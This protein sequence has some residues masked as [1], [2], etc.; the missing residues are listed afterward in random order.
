MTSI[1]PYP[2][3]ALAAVER[4]DASLERAARSALT[5]WLDA[6]ALR[7]AAR[8]LLGADIAL[9][10]RP[11]QSSGAW[12]V[13]ELLLANDRVVHL[14]LESDLGF[15]VAARVLGR[16]A[17]IVAAGALPGDAV[18][19]S[20]A[21]SVVAIA[22]RSGHPVRVRSARVDVAAPE[23]RLVCLAH[24]VVLGDDAF[25]AEI[26]ID[27][28]DA[29]RSPPR[30]FDRSA[31]EALGAAP[32][33]LPIVAGDA[34]STVADV[35]ALGVGDVWVGGA[36]ALRA[37][38]G[39]VVGDVMLV[40]PAAERGFFASLTE[41]GQVVIRD[42]VAHAPWA[43]EGEATMSDGDE[44]IEAMGD[45][46]VVVRVEVGSVEMPAREWAALGAGDVVGLGRRVGEPAIL[47]VGGV[48]VARGELV[49][50]EGEVGVRIVR[51]AG[52]RS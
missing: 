31:L 32:V 10:P 41:T 38:R 25:V 42:G 7:E 49:D 46:P 45:V 27:E 14:A 24:T 11:R 51:L 39:V 20:V 5:T 40:P 52:D 29:F 3:R 15:H 16:A 22:R 9:R 13:V 30:R 4:R 47:R 34:L 26:R 36:H 18:A 33:R 2:V 17:P 37:Q 6:P 44:R 35:A 28:A 1:R 23:P 19:A 43:P 50:L 8:A 12:V 48:E 21:A